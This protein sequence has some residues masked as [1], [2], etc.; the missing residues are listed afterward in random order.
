M[1]ELFGN[2]YARKKERRGFADPYLNSRAIPKKK[3]ISQPYFPP[4]KRER[5][6]HPPLPK[7]NKETNRS[8]PLPPPP[9]YP[10]PYA[11]PES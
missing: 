2:K 4:Q 5:V 3:S 11:Q 8:P 7:K 9:D 10:P 1:K 6:N